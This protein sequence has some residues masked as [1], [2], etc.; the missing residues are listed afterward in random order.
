MCEDF[1]ERR[2]ISKDVCFLFDEVYPQKSE[3]YFTGDQKGCDNNGNLYIGL[4]CFM[5]IDLEGSVPYVIKSS[6]ETAINAGW[7]KAE[8]FG[9][10][11]CFNAMWF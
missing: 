6:P 8:V 7:P 4:G 2:K 10:P 3:Q 9:G 1:E 11:D 5:I